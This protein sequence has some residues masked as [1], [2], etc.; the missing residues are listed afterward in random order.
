[1]SNYVKFTVKAFE[2]KLAA[3]EYKDAAGANRAIGRAAKFTDKQRARLRERVTHYFVNKAEEEK[4][5]KRIGKIRISQK[6]GKHAHSE[7]RTV[8][9]RA[10]ARPPFPVTFTRLAMNKKLAKQTLGFFQEA[11]DAGYTLPD[12]THALELV[13]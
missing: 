2:D 4:V 13:V 3:G 1:L 9:E 11:L 10:S 7:P 8:D 12:L 6:K 5:K